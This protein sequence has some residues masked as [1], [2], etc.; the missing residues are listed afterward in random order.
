MSRRNDPMS[1]RHWAGGFYELAL[2]V[3]PSDEERVA[4]W[5]AALVDATGLTCPTVVDGT[6]PA[7]VA[8]EERALRKAGEALVRGA[9]VRGVVRLPEGEEVACGL[10]LLQGASDD[11]TRATHAGAD[12]ANLNWLVLY[13]PL[14]G[15]GAAGVEVDG[16]PFDDRS[17]AE[18]L[19]W[20]RPLDE[21]LAGLGRSVHRTVPFRRAVIGFE[22]AG[23]DDGPFEPDWLAPAAPRDRAHLVV[24]RAGLTY[25]AAEH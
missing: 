2:Q 18:S 7:R 24:G 23:D 22:V 21:W 19:T 9:H 10:L 13:L 11:G 17:G 25:V 15:L 14:A 12:T 20:R 3:G 4:A 8:T 16:F 5:V 6:D 1:H